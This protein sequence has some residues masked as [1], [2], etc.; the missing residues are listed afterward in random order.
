MRMVY[1]ERLQD[2][3]CYGDTDVFSVEEV[4][5]LPDFKLKLLFSNGER[6]I[7]DARGLFQYELFAPLQNAALFMQAHSD[8]CAVAWNDEIDIAP[9]AL[10]RDSIPA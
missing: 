7:Y 5:A 8:G 6:R 1:D 3:I 2:Y 10:Y 4:E 9:E